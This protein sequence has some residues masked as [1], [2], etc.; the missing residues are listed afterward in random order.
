M[1]TIRST[2]KTETEFDWTQLPRWD[3]PEFLA[4]QKALAKIPRVAPMPIW[5]DA[6]FKAYQKLT[7]K[8]N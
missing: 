4:H 8:F 7:R 2:R 3:S 5:S 6:K 1:K